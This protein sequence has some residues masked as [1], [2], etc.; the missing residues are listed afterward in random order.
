MTD[1]TSQDD[2]TQSLSV[3]RQAF[4]ILEHL[5]DVESTGVTELANELD[6]PKT[7]AHSYLKTLENTGYAINEDGRYRLSLRILRHAGQL[8]HSFTLYQVGRSQVDRLARE[9]GEA[10]N[11]GVPE[12]GERV[13]IYGAEGENAIWDDVPIGSRTPLN[14]TAIGK[15][16]LSHWSEPRLRAFLDGQG[17]GEA[18]EH[19]LSD[20]DRIVAELE[21]TR[22]R[23]YSV[24]DEEHIVGVRAF[25]MPI[26]QS[27]G[28]VIGAMSIT[29]PTSR[30][31][32]TETEKQLVNELR[33]TVNIIELRHEQY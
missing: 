21:E 14:L 24:E 23:G 3:V 1:T 2:G 11:L 20:E 10:V 15:A 16:I 9:T 32:Q 8:R 5:T 4:E 6:V 13:I 33:E 17:L 26:K 19:S 27:D 30:L 18:T 31:S 22:E 12:G 28:T 7:T 25:G 29:G